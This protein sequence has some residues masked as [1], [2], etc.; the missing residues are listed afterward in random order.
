[1]KPTEEECK[2]IKAMAM[3]MCAADDDPRWKPYEPAALRQ[4]AANKAM[5]AALFAWQE[6]TQ[7]KNFDDIMGKCQKVAT[8]DFRR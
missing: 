1:M 2:I 5:T 3:A 8:L 7:R 6:A 4:Y